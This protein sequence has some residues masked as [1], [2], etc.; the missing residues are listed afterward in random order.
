VKTA[1]I[2]F[3]R[4]EFV[5]RGSIADA[6]GSRALFPPD[7][8]TLE[9][10]NLL[11]LDG[12]KYRYE[13]HHP[14]FWPG[15]SWVRQD[16]VSAFNGSVAATFLPRGPSGSGSPAGTVYNGASDV[17][18][19][20]FTLAPLGLTLR[21]LNPAL[22]PYRRRLMRPTGNTLP[23]DGAPCREYRLDVPLRLW[24]DPE[25][26]YVV[27]RVR[28]GAQQLDVSYR[29][30]SGVWVP[31]SWVVSRLSQDGAALVMDKVEVLEVRLNEPQPAE[32]FDLHFP[33]GCEVHDKRTTPAKNYVVEPDG[34]LRELP[35]AEEGELSPP[36]R[37]PAG[38]WY[39]RN[40]WLLAGLGV[41]VVG[42]MVEH[43]ARRRR[44]RKAP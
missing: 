43:V 15:G 21:W 5:P 1:F 18:L 23:L 32:L 24:L 30:V 39:W 4:T 35:R 19:L 38:P 29:R 7:D 20:P 12:E 22:N 8:V 33:P 44:G 3:K 2:T 28:T 13:D 36:P 25:K 11:V 10:V 6:T 27:R 42:L 26:D 31:D 16:M 34:S 41:V 40:R 14:V 9:S 37:E 17:A